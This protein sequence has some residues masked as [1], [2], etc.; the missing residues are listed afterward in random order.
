MSKKIILFSVLLLMTPALALASTARLEGLGVIP[1]YVEDYANIF[2]YPASICRYPAVVVGELGYSDGWGKGFGA[3]MGLGQDNAYGVLGIMLRENSAFAPIPGDWTNDGSQFDLLWGMNFEK[4]TFGVRFDNT[5][6]K[7]EET[8]QDGNGYAVS[9]YYIYYV[10]EDI[11]MTPNYLNSTGVAVSAAMDVR[12]ADKIEATFEYRSLGFSYEELGTAFEVTDQGEPSYGFWG[13]GFFAMNDKV[14]IVPMVG[15][16]KYDYSWEV[17]SD[18]PDEE[19]ASDQTLSYMRAGVGM[20]VDVGSF[21]MLGVGLSQWK[22]NI[23]NTF[24]SATP[25]GGNVESFE[26]TGTS[27][28]FFFGT[29]EADLRDW[30]TIRFGAKK[31]LINE[32]ATIEWVDGSSLEYKTKNSNIV[33]DVRSG[34]LSEGIYLPYFE[35]PFVFSMGLGF[36]WNDIEIDATLNED[37][38]FTGM[39]WLSGVSE[40]PFGKISVTYYY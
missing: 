3:T 5:S 4:L 31:N 35:E 21:F 8:D 9:P 16:N 1:D 22:L 39:Y 23:D 26:Y 20:K 15:Y 34:L 6:S 40:E 10:G 37:Y 7:L 32:D 11:L 17:K 30:L 12:D 36:K 19:D 2:S 27:L 25:P 14:T 28:P 29:F 18:I 33:S 13:R 38:P 24:G